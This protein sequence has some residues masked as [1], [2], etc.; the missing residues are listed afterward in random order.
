M[1]V[2]ASALSAQVQGQC[3][4]S[5]AADPVASLQHVAGHP[6][7]RTSKRATVQVSLL[8]I[9]PIVSGSMAVAMTG[10]EGQAELLGDTEVWGIGWEFKARL[11]SRLRLSMSLC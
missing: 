3:R 6:G 1:S 4:R 8:L 10:L 11:G 9:S 7:L 2:P 5:P